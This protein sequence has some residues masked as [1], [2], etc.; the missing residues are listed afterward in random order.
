MA[1]D[2]E[3]GGPPEESS[4]RTFVLAAAGIGGLL[5]L[6]LICLGLY[7]LVLAPRQRQASA[8][9]ATQIALENTQVAA[10][11]TATAG[12]RFPSATVPSTRTNTPTNTPTRTATAVVVVA[13]PTATVST[14]TIDP[15]AATAAFLATRA[16]R[17]PTRTVTALPV[18]GFADEGGMPMLVLLGGALVLVAVVA[19]RMRLRPLG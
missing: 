8:D 1:E 19:R 6:S 15:A 2:F 7:A 5:V 10:A 3:V 13:S 12:A 4:N 18:T 14:G 16:A 17:T 9:R 11:I